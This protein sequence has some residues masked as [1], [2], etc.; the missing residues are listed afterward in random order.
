MENTAAFASACSFLGYFLLNNSQPAE[1]LSHLTRALELQ[2]KLLPPDHP[3]IADTLHKIALANGHLGNAAAA[4][5][6]AAASSAVERRSQS[7]CAGPGCTRNVKPDGR[8]LEQCGKCRRTYYCSVGCQ[9]ADWK[10]EGGHKAECKALV[11]EG[12]GIV[13]TGA[14]DPPAG[15]AGAAAVGKT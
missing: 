5:Q 13:P 3:E 7:R 4:T 9:T 6:A 10:R 12:G 11:A 1:A 8:P 15:G 14:F 2:R